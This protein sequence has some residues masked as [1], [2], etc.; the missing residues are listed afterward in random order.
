MKDTKP[1]ELFTKEEMASLF[2]VDPQTIWNY[3]SEGMPV[4]TEKPVRFDYDECLEWLKTRT[5]KSKE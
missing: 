2:K 1:K 4:V 3:K 5:R